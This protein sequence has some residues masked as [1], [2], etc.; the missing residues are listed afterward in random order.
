MI[1]FVSTPPFL[2]ITLRVAMATMHFYIAQT[3]LFLG[4]L[5]LHTKGVLGNNLAPMRNCLWSARLVKL[6]ARVMLRYAVV[7][8]VFGSQLYH[9]TSY[10]L[11][12]MLSILL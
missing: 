11:N 9:L 1:T 2:R 12:K 3:G 10:R 6:D 7:G 5:F 8:G 4:T